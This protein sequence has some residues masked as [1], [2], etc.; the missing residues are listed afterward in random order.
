M[1]CSSC[2]TQKFGGTPWK[3]VDLF[4]SFSTVPEYK[5]QNVKGIEFKKSDF[6]LPEFILL[7][8]SK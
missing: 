4:E 8:G 2:G 1:Y 7:S 5:P 3:K 6:L